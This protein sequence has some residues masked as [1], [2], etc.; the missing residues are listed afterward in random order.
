M[1]TIFEFADEA[2]SDYLRHLVNDCGLM[3]NHVHHLEADVLWKHHDHWNDLW[4]QRHELVKNANSGK[5]DS[6]N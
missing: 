6:W 1:H 2:Q 4:S 3:L 5:G